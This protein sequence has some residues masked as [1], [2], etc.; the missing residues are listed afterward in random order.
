MFA[1]P[2]GR[3]DPGVF[4]ISRPSVTALLAPRRSPRRRSRWPNRGLRGLDSDR[5]FAASER[6]VQELRWTLRQRQ[7]AMP[8]LSA[9]SSRAA[10]TCSGVRGASLI[11]AGVEVIGGD[12]AGVDRLAQHLGEQAPDRLRPRRGARF[13]LRRD[14]GVQRWTR[15]AFAT[16]YAVE[17]D[18]GGKD[19]DCGTVWPPGEALPCPPARSVSNAGS[20][21]FEARYDQ[22]LEGD[23]AGVFNLLLVA[24]F[25][26][27]EF[28]RNPATDSEMKPATRAG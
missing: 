17:A 15:R 20:F 8:A 12:R 1:F 27:C 18:D 25:L 5:I 3:G 13:G 11:V 9:T 26:W 16:A 14:P 28:R 22:G 10:L 23:R 2:H 24:I 21:F 6:P 4:F 19:E 7:F